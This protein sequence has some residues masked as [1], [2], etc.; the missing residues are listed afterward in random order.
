MI[1]HDEIYYKERKPKPDLGFINNFKR[2][3]WDPE[4][5]SLLG[6]NAEQWGKC[7]FLMNKLKNLNKIILMIYYRH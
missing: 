2:F 4:R 1:K 7:K 5:K 3:L 6:R